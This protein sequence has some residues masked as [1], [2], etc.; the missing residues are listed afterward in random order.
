MRGLAQKDSP[1]IE[2]MASRD[3]QVIV[4][5]ADDLKRQSLEPIFK[6]R[7]EKGSTI[8]S[9]TASC[10]DFLEEDGYHHEPVN[11]SKKEYARGEDLKACGYSGCS[12]SFHSVGWHSPICL[13]MLRYSNFV[14]TIAT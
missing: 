6:K 12:L 11:H 7:V 14:Q 4:E 8:Y 1:A 5:V 3:G 13:N 2:G 9:D 10:Y